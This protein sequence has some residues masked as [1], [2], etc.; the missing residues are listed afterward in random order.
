MAFD[1]K[2]IEEHPWYTAGIIAGG[3]LLLFLYW[4]SGSSGSVASSAT[5][6]S[7]YSDPSVITA[8]INAATAQQQGNLQVQGQV[9]QLNA[10]V[11]T[12]TIQANA[13]LALANSNNSTA[14]QNSQI[15]SATTIQTSQIQAAT[16]TT[17]TGNTLQSQID[18]LQIQGDTAV[19]LGGQQTTVALGQQSTD[20]SAL[21]AQYDN[22]T[23]IAT[24]TNQTA[25]LV[26]NNQTN[27][28]HDSINAGLIASEDNTNANYQLTAGLIGLLGGPKLSTS[29]PT[30]GGI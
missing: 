9:N 19:K 30:S 20:L 21:T 14:I 25:Q 16:S 26:S 12:D 13:A 6:S 11:A 28:V 15:A 17:N 1:F 2:L 7:P 18:Q 4:N 22:A 3:G 23:K 5:V 10:Q 29:T 27:N 8:G 24:L